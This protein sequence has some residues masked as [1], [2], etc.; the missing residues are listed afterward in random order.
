MQADYDNEIKDIF[1]DFL[2]I[3]NNYLKNNINDLKF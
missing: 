3:K 1:Y 2:K